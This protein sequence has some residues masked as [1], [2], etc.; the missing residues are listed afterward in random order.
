MTCVGSFYPGFGDFDEMSTDGIIDTINS[1]NADFLAVALGAQKGQMWL[2]RN[3]ER[4]RVPVR[5]HL[6]ATINFQAGTLK[7]APISMQKWGLEWLW[8][9]KEEPQ[10]W[11][12]YWNDGIAMLLLL[13]TRVMPIIVMSW[14]DQL[15][16]A[17][18]DSNLQ[19]TQ[20]DSRESV[21]FNLNGV[22]TAKNVSNTLPYFEKAVADSKNVVINFTDTRQIDAR[23]L[24]LILMLNKQLKKQGHRLGFTGV[25][26][27]I[28]RIFRLNGFGFLLSPVEQ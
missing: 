19:I 23:F 4:L 26:S 13:L 16:S 21:I 8:R 6:G 25:S 27:R 10:L 5:V 22:A 18:D 3:H 14:W 12:R 24:G 17:G 7:R 15:R 20:T 9:I 11:K 2:R 1:S 28:A